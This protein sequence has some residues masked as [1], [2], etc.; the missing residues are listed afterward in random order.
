M[1]PT[2]SVVQIL[3]LAIALALLTVLLAVVPFERIE[4]WAIDLGYYRA[5]ALALRDGA[6]PYVQENL[7]KYADG[8]YIDE[9]LLYTYSPVF[10][11]FMRPLT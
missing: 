8:A 6:D 5:A 9:M 1:V 3:V 4:Y 2:R 10:A 7:F 11:L